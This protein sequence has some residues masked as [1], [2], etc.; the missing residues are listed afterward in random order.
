MVFPA[1]SALTHS[2]FIVASSKYQVRQLH[3][4]FLINVRKQ[5]VPVMCSAKVPWMEHFHKSTE[6]IVFL[7]YTK[8]KLWEFI[9]G[10]V[11]QF[12]WKKAESIALHELVILGKETLKWCLLAFLAF[13]CLSDFFYSISRNKEL[14]IPFGLFVG[15]LTTNYLDKISQEFLRDHKDGNTTWILVG[16][17]CFFVLVK[18]I[19][20]G[21]DFLLHAAN[22]GLMQVLWNWK[23]LPKLDGE[24]SLLEDASTMSNAD[25]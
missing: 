4:S 21:N 14:L 12:P 15:C 2:T 23:N 16:I 11:K 22:G 24:K 17:S 6:L 9:P 10:S 19:S 18:V 25:G 20:G 5:H 13:S 1:A 3:S 8:D 7:N